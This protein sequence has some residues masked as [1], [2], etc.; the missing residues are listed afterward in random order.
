MDYLDIEQLVAGALYYGFDELKIHTLPLLIEDFLNKNTNCTF[1]GIN[2]TNQLGRISHINLNGEMVRIANDIHLK[3][4][5]SN[6]ED[7][8]QDL[9]IIAG[10][11]VVE[12][13]DKLVLTDF[14]LK[15]IRLLNYRYSL[16]EEKEIFSNFEIT[17]IK[18]L[19]NNGYLMEVD[20]SRMGFSNTKISI[21]ELGQARLFILHH[22]EEVQNF[23]KKLDS[24]RYNASY[25]EEFLA[26]QDLSVDTDSILTCERFAQFCKNTKKELFL[27]GTTTI[28]F[29]IMSNVVKNTNMAK[30]LTIYDKG[31]SI[32]MCHPDEVFNGAS[33]I[34]ADTNNVE[35]IS[36]NDI[37]IKKIS[38][39]AKEYELYSSALNSLKYK[40]NKQNKNSNIP[41]AYLVILEKY[42]YRGKKNYLVRGLV[43]KQDRK[44]YA[45]FNP[46]YEES[47]PNNSAETSARING[48]Y[49]PSIYL[50]KRLNYK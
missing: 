2:N 32:V 21:T 26:S 24:K 6:K 12:Y 18:E 45:A 35:C 7:A 13:F 22:Q 20:P 47:I 23:R 42:Y 43:K 15:K 3:E 28:S 31:H 16:E 36:W 19:L 25:I 44:F 50:V 4:K 34:S 30:L 1:I 37:N 17:G 27:P 29:N 10:F 40:L 8:K 41:V 38:K 46:E 48:Q 14:L 39:Q 11:R 49:T 5:F 9:K 33:I